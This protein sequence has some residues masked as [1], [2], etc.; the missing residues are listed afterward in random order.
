VGAAVFCPGI[1]LCLKFRLPDGLSIYF[2]EAYAIYQ[3]LKYILDNNIISA[4]IISDSSRVL[5]DIKSTRFSKSPHP[6]ILSQILSLLHHNPVI[7]IVFKWIPGHCNSSHMTS[8]D[9]LAKAATRLDGITA[10]NHSYDEAILAVDGW[11]WKKWLNFW[12]QSKTCTYQKIFTLNKSLKRFNKSR[13][14]DIIITRLRLHQNRLNAGLFK[15][16]LHE[17]GKCSACGSLDDSIHFILN[18]SN[19]AELTNKLLA[20]VKDSKYWNYQ[21]IMSNQATVDIIV[22][23][24]IEK[25][26]E[27]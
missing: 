10:I 12:E 13:R 14:K 23:Y 17:D 21:F 15:L 4:Y 27:I 8:T 9:I 22:D 19:T 1:S 2:A 26:I 5:K 3:A 16:G 25:D 7:T 24:V 18:C 6:T 20:E 11:I